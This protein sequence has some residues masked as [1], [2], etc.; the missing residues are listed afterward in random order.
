[1]MIRLFTVLE[2]ISDSIK[3]EAVGAIKSLRKRGAKR[4][5]MLSGDRRDKAECVGNTLGFDDVYAELSPKEKYDK[6]ESI[7]ET[8]VKTVYV[9]DGINDAP[10]IARSDVGIAMGA[11]GSDSAIENA[12]IV[13]TS[14][15]LARIPEAVRVARKT[16]GIAT[17]NIIFAIGVKVG[18][19][20]LG[21]L[22]LTNM[23]V[24]V[25]A[26]VGVAVIAILNAM[27]ALKQK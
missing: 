12:D 18:V 22:G 2:Q 4:I 25:F 1:M 17:Q 16:V 23:W 10:S 7:I 14:D 5:I 11:V 19:L 6:L 24:A 21:A 3:S 26:D 9:G 27:R 20:I 8:S 15:N 13:I